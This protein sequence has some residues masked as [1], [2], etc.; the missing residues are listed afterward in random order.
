MRRYVVLA[1][2][3]LALVLLASACRDSGSGQDMQSM[4]HGGGSQ[5]RQAEEKTDERMAG[6]DHSNMG[7]GSM[8]SDDM[9]RQMVMEDGKDSDEAFIDAMVPHHQGAVEMAKMALKYA[10]HEEI[11]EL[12][13]NIV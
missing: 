10:E 13:R 6:M 2:L 5:G 3:A 11:M 7:H 8:S 1:M 9:A 4:D 12:S